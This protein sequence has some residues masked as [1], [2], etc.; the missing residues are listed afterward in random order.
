MSRKKSCV[1]C[2]V[3]TNFISDYSVFCG[4]NA[5]LFGMEQDCVQATTL[6]DGITPTSSLQ[7]GEECS[8]EGDS[9][10]LLG[11]TLLCSGV[12]FA[13]ESKGPRFE[14]RNYRNWLG[15]CKSLQL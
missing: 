2:H 6:V 7:E 9:F 12:V 11:Q 3:D 15:T 5:G 4:I 1:E 14:S 10:A 8:D 13:S